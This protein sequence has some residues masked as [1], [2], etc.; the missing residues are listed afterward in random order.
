MDQD[1]G[2]VKPPEGASNTQR[3]QRESFLVR[4]PS[5]S[6]NNPNGNATTSHPFTPMHA[7][8]ATPFGSQPTTPQY[9]VVNSNGPAA[10]PGGLERQP[11]TSVENLV[12]ISDRQQ[13]VAKLGIH[14]TS[15]E[16]VMPVLPGQEFHLASWLTSGRTLAEPTWAFRT[17]V[18]VDEHRL[19]G[20]WAVLRRRH[21]IMRSTLVAVRP[22]EAFTVVLRQASGA[23]NY[24]TFSKARYYE[25]TLE[26]RV[27][28][29]MKKLATRPS[30]LKTPPTRLTL[31]QGDVQE[32]DAVLI[33][34]HHAACDTR[35]MGLIMQEL[36]DLYRGK[37][38]VSKAP[39]FRNFVKETLFTHDREAE[40]E[41]WKDTLRDCEET[42]VL[43]ET[44]HEGNP[45]KKNEIVVKGTKTSTSS[46]EKAAE[47]ASVTPPTIIYLAFSHILAERTGSSR[48]VFGC[49]HNGRDAVEGVDR[50]DELVGPC[51]T[52][53]PTTIPEDVD[54]SHELDNSK[55]ELI[56]SL[57]SVHEHLNSQVAY[58][59]SRLRDVLRW[60][61]V[62]DTVPF[63]TYLNILWNTK[64][65]GAPEQTSEEE[66]DDLA[67]ERMDLGMRSNY[68][69]A[70][71]IPG[72]TTVDVLDTST[73]M[74][75]QNV[76]VDVG[77][78]REE[79]GGGV[80]EI[81]LS[82]NE[83][84]MSADDLKAF[85]EQIDGEV[86]AV[87]ECLMK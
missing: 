49:F 84:L 3:Q 59:Q 82:A 78:D 55:S 47:V 14:D 28:Q 60:A 76:F 24:A 18:P 11:T 13:A 25:G 67:W 85:A 38:V 8:D 64:L 87:V 35:S 39:S 32:G 45:L 30:T 68:S 43:P 26:E 41:F 15:V 10:R 29:E 66:T 54:V 70:S 71:A 9:E 51:S 37:P 65:Q 33:T 22:D 23:S 4:L 86:A 46:L 6:L 81:R 56:K 42:I 17:K 36:T 40:E 31:V 12:S 58:E 80:L 20:A 1:N 19:R 52:M 2:D 48:P 83:V 5:R 7:G 77:S 34:I 69:A 44:D 21:P 61:D 74:R 57:Q 27:K 53:L 79:D 16:A 50:V 73:V 72:Q 75:K 62:G 63:N